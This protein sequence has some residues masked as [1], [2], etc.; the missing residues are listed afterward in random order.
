M[1]CRGIR[2]LLKSTGEMTRWRETRSAAARRL[3]VVATE[4]SDGA[5]ARLG[6]GHRLPQA[7]S[8][9]LRA[10]LRAGGAAVVHR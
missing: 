6:P 10:F 8:E 7:E 5:V 3:A 2:R 4:L 9:Q 1:D